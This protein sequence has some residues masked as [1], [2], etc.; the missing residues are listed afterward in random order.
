MVLQAIRERL[1]GIIAVFIFAIL[2]IPF[3]FVGVNS[4]FTSDTVNAARTESS[5]SPRTTGDRVRIWGAT[6]ARA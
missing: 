3:A 6:Q 5:A 2:I 1:T 4:Y